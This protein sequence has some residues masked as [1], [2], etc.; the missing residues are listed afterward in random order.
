MTAPA[1]RSL[2]S[3]GIEQL[4]RAR[5]DD[6]V[7]RGMHQRREQHQQRDMQR[8]AHGATP[9]LMSGRA[10]ICAGNRFICP[11]R[12]CHWRRSIASLS[13]PRNNGKLFT[14]R[15]DGKSLMQVGTG[16]STI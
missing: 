14:T 12:F 3:S 16:L 11:D 4:A 8:Q 1:M 5:F 7:P 2:P 9:H 6:R 15:E 13:K 10:S